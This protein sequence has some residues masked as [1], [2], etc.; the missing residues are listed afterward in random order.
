MLA[1][2]NAGNFYHTWTLVFKSGAILRL[3]DVALVRHKDSNGG[4]RKLVATR[5]VPMGAEAAMNGDGKYELPMSEISGLFIATPE[6]V[7]QKVTQK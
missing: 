2:D 5:S 4:T 1:A 3:K 7:G 6:D